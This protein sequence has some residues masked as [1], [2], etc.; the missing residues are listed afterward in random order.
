MTSDQSG[1]WRSLTERATKET[2]PNKMLA[3]ITELN[4]VLERESARS[5]RT[6]DPHRRHAF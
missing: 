4:R 1:D 2:D 6:S 5:A 3:I